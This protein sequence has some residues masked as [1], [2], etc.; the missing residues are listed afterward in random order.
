MR[1]IL[2]LSALVTSL[3]FASQAQAAGCVSGAIV[4]G[5][6]GHMVGHGK[7]GAVAGCVAGHEK[8]KKDED[9]KKRAAQSQPAQQQ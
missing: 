4:G 6:A 5:V 8:A 2:I 9:A 7:V 1:S 3:A